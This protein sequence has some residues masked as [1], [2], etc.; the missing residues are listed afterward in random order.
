MSINAAGRIY[1]IRILSKGERDGW[2]GHRFPNIGTL[3]VPS[4][5]NPEARKLETFNVSTFRPVSKEFERQNLTSFEFQLLAKIPTFVK[6]GIYMILLCFAYHPPETE[7]IINVFSAS[8]G[9]GY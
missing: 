2:P 4:F 3:N 6:A 5:G 1:A 7:N 8:G 9:P